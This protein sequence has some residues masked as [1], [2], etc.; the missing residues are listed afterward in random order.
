[1]R[2]ALARDVYTYRVLVHG[3]YILSSFSY[4]RGRCS[5]CLAR[6]CTHYCDTCL[7][8]GC[9]EHTVTEETCTLCQEE[10]YGGP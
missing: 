6:L 7:R 5:T 3:S 4:P 1:M 9:S 8:C 10:Q 2:P